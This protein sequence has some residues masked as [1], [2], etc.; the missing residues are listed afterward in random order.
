MRR[1]FL[2]SAMLAIVAIASLAGCSSDNGDGS[3]GKGAM[4]TEARSAV[5]EDIASQEFA[6]AAGFGDDLA[7]LVY[8][9]GVKPSSSLVRRSPDGTLIGM[10]SERV[11]TPIVTPGIP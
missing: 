4:H 8:K 10:P 11:L 7:I 1:S 3:A 9:R 5:I 2:I 6:G